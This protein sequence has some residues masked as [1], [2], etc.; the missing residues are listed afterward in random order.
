LTRPDR[1]QDS[2]RRLYHAL[3]L[4]RVVEEEVARVYPTDV[5]KSPV[6]LSIGQEFVSV[7]V[8]DVLEPRDH[9]SITYRGHAAYIAKGGDLNAMIAEMYGK[10]AGCAQG[11]GGSMHLVDTAAGVIGASAVVGTSIPVAAGY[12]LAAKRR[13]DGAVVACFI[14]DGATEEGCFAETLNFAA[15]HALP[16]LFICENNGY[17]I[18]EPLSKRWATNRL[19]ERVETYG[20]PARRIEDGDVFS[21]RAAAAEV[22]AAMRAGRGPAFLEVACYRWR[23]HVGPNEDFNQGYRSASEK[24]P[25]EER[26]QVTALAAMLPPDVVAV[27]EADVAARVRDAFVFAE[28]QPF[29]SPE[30]L[31]DHVYA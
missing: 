12:A 24:T 7:G 3:R 5:I 4:I 28:T 30:D 19:C 11:R 10:K 31:Y 16:V 29:P 17:A 26:D 21:V 27:V 14:G 15:L 20:V 25:W 13:G 18:H 8:C 6:H 1:I 23:E 2:T 22:V 9:V